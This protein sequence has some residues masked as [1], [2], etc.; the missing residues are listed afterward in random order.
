MLEITLCRYVEFFFILSVWWQSTP[1]GRD[2]LVCL[3]SPLN[4]L[5]Q[6]LS[7]ICRGV[8]LGYIL[9]YKIGEWRGKCLRNFVRY[10]CHNTRSIFYCYI[11]YQAR[12]QHFSTS[13]FLVTF[14]I[15]LCCGEFITKGKSA[16]LIVQVFI[17]GRLPLSL[18]GRC[19]S[20]SPTLLGLELICKKS[21][22]PRMHFYQGSP[23]LCSCLSLLLWNSCCPI[24]TI[25]LNTYCLTCCSG[26][27]WYCNLNMDVKKWHLVMD[28]LGSGY[29]RWGY[30]CAF[31][32][33]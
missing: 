31:V 11:F 7:P 22:I 20:L 14:S 29:R 5:K 4:N 21:V 2:N 17:S 26:N 8:S 10:C 9:R 15:H 25:Y 16:Q 1:L 30:C 32:T 28:L 24:Y 13:R 33:E 23:C 12:R 3:T 27:F 18:L 19:L 6:I